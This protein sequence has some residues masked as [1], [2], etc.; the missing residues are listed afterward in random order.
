ME[1]DKRT[2]PAITTATIDQQAYSEQRAQFLQD[3]FRFRQGEF[4]YGADA[5]N[6]LTAMFYVLP[7]NRYFML[8]EAKTKEFLKNIDD[9]L[10]AMETYRMTS[11]ENFGGKVRVPDFI[12]RL[13][14]LFFELGKIMNECGYSR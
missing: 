9:L 3:Y 1:T 10:I 14:G 5:L 2:L 6:H 13:D 11:S 7:A 12:K 4:K 8:D